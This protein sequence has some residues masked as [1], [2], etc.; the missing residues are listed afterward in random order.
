MNPGVSSLSCSGR[1]ACLRALVRVEHHM[2]DGARGWL[3]KPDGGMPTSGPNALFAIRSQIVSKRTAIRGPAL[4][5]A[6]A[7]SC[8][9]THYTSMRDHIHGSAGSRPRSSAL[10][11]WLVWAAAAGGNVLVPPQPA[12]LNDTL[13]GV[14]VLF[15]LESCRWWPCLASAVWL[16]GPGGLHCS[17][18]PGHAHRCV[19][20]YPVVVLVCESTRIVFF[21]S[22]QLCNPPYSA[23][24]ARCAAS[25]AHV[26]QSG[27]L[28]LR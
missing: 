16:W 9:C 20:M 17:T 21:S 7:G 6:D 24:P 3:H 19:C 22:G 27:V 4:Q 14:D 23:A 26:Q 15:W 28:L 1:N 18:V 25:H 13:M 10:P 12:A 8:A 5:I 11:G 2:E